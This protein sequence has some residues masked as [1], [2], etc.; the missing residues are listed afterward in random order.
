MGMTRLE[1]TMVQYFS[2]KKKE[3]MT[4]EEDEGSI[5]KKYC[6]VCV[7][8]VWVGHIVLFG[9]EVNYHPKH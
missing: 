2:K 1:I 8:E 3:V 6:Q 7:M 9:H 4:N 5:Y